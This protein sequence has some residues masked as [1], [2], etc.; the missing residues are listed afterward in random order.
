M[1]ARSLSGL[2][3]A[4]LVGWGCGGQV[5]DSGSEGDSP[6]SASAA[7]GDGGS[8]YVQLGPC[9]KGFDPRLEVGRDCDWLADGFCYPTKEAACAC[10]CPT[11][12]PAT[13]LSG[14]FQGTGR[15]TK[16]SCF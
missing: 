6:A 2:W 9:Q 3:M 11:D 14:F 8:E 5:E 15:K 10:I 13:C 1:S 12:H 7:D 4:L 16:V